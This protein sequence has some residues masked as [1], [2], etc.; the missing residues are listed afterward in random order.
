MKTCEFCKDKVEETYKL[1]DLEACEDC[2][3][4]LSFQDLEDVKNE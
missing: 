4:D 3:E 2:F 1:D